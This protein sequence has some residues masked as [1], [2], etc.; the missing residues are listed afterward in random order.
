MTVLPFQLGGF[1]GVGPLS[2]PNDDAAT[3]TGGSSGPMSIMKKARAMFRPLTAE[4]IEKPAPARSVMTQA[5][6]PDFTDQ[7]DEQLLQSYLAGHREAFGHLLE[8]YRNELSHF[9]IRFLGSRAA[10][11]DVFQETFLQVHLSGETFDPSRRFKP[12]LFTIAANKARDYHRRN[13][14]RQP[15]SL[16][17]SIGDEG[18]SQTF[19]DLLQ[20][21]LPSPDDPLA[22]AE[23]SRLIRKVV[24]EMPVHLRE[25]LL[26]SYFQ[27]LS[28]NQIADSL[29]IPLGTVKSRLHTAVA[30]FAR[31]WKLARAT[32]DSRHGFG[33]R[34]D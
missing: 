10:A 21:D 3:Q 26:M 16:S 9:L 14:K 34:E 1:A 6:F 27:R 5:D 8:R 33:D 4:D 29:E 28:Y 2:L 20:A 31:A 7:S 24:D 19:V 18:E 23:R 15:L 25:I 11:D 17:A 13:T 32:D 30:T 22:D 12:W